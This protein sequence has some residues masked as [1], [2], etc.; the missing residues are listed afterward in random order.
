[1][2]QSPGDFVHQSGLTITTAVYFQNDSS[3]YFHHFRSVF[4]NGLCK[5][6]EFPSLYNEKKEVSLH[7]GCSVE[8]V[9]FWRKELAGQNEQCLHS[10]PTNHGELAIYMGTGCVYEVEVVTSTYSVTAGGA[11]SCF[12][13]VISH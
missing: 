7:L 1:M 4:H 8:A 13:F 6:L 2:D 9:L 10:R 12:L 3:S 11:W 5:C